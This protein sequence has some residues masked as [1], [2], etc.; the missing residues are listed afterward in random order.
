MKTIIIVAIVFLSSHLFAEGG[1]NQRGAP[2]VSDRGIVS[3][4]QKQ[5]IEDGGVWVVEGDYIPG[6][7]VCIND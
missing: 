6:A 7:G 5:C 1:K 3:E 2:V 4:I